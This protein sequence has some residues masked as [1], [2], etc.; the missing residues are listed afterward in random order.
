MHLLPPFPLPLAIL[1]P[2]ITWN[3]QPRITFCKI[4][5]PGTTSDLFT[6]PNLWGWSL[7]CP[8]KSSWGDSNMQS[9]LRSPG[10]VACAPNAWPMTH[11]NLGGA[12]GRTATS[13][14][15]L[16]ITLGPGQGI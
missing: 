3:S 15:A 14:Q 16:P 11:V 10:P 6:N 12:S 8:F 13:S 4:Q 1:Q 7:L 2:R 5:M 9:R